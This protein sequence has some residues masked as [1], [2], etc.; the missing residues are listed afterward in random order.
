MNRVNIDSIA[1]T[2]C[3]INVCIM[4][5]KETSIIIINYRKRSKHS[6]RDRLEKKENRNK[7]QTLSNEN[8][9]HM[10]LDYSLNF[11]HIYW[12]ILLYN[13]LNI[14]ALKALHWLSFI[15][16]TRRS[17]FWDS[18]NNFRELFSRRL[19]AQI[20]E[21]FYRNI[22]TEICIMERWQAIGSS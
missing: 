18:M 19:L 1:C 5:I 10:C 14:T 3:Q 13:L 21:T 12:I 7:T 6:T 2:H 20:C 16:G 11:R 9:V 22:L 15:N 17:A 4:W 8:I